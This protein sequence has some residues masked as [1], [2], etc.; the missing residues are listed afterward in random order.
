MWNY[1][2]EVTGGEYEGKF[3]FVKSNNYNDAYKQAVEIM[4]TDEIED[5]GRYYDCD[6]KIM[7]YDTY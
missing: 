5:R 7:D 3:F 4:G 6:A 2:F 1:L